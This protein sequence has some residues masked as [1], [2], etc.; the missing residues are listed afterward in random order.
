MTK[1]YFASFTMDM[2]I[3]DTAELVRLAMERLIEDGYSEQEAR[4]YY[5]TG[6]DGKPDLGR[7]V[8]TLYDNATL[9][10]MACTSIQESSCEISDLDD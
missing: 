1:R 7:A 3:T 2:E 4:D 5:Y 6:E 8:R 10:Q 9:A